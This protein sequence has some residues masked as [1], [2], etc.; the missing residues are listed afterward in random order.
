MADFK[1]L[2]C[3]A[4]AFQPFLTSWMPEE[5][6]VESSEHQDDANIHCQP[7]PELI[8]EEREIYADYD[9]RHRHPVKHHN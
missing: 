9:G 8:S 6:K 7:F 4:L 1:G 3:R 2:R 5:S